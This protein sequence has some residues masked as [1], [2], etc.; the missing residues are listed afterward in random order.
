MAKSTDSVSRVLNA[1]ED[2]ELAARVLD[3]PDSTRTAEK[4][5]EAVGC[6]VSQ[7]VKSLVFVS[8]KGSH[9]ILIL[10][11][12]S[13]RVDEN[14]IATQINQKVKF[15]DADFVREKTGFAI[16][17]VA[18]VGHINPIETFI[19]QDLLKYDEIWAAA[20]NPHMV[21]S[22]GPQDLV[23]AC[24]GKVISVC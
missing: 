4:A 24:K 3:L 14:L 23:K 18:P 1:L 10:T 9:P 21:F 6:D 8:D 13:N 20:G 15:A 5:A 16:G 7:I 22:I 2:L 11:S 19:D 17:G 12:G